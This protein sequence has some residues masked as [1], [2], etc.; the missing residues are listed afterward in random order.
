MKLLKKNGVKA[1]KEF[2]ENK[3]LQESLRFLEKIKDLRS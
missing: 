3:M 2:S 1:E